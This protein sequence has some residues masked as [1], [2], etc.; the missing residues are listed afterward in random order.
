MDESV[1]VLAIGD[2]HFKKNYIH[3]GKE[4]FSEI[5]KILNNNNYDFVVLLGDI[6]HDHE[7]VDTTTFNLACK[8][9]HKI[10]EY[11]NVFLII[12][13]HDYINN[14]QF[15][16]NNHPFNPLKKWKGVNVIDKPR[17]VQCKDKQFL[18]CPYVYPGRFIEAM[19]TIDDWYLSDCI[20]C[21][22]EFKGCKMGAFI[23]E[24]GDDWDTSYPQVVSGH[25]HDSQTPQDNIF[26]TGS[27]IQHGFNES[28][29]KYIFELLYSNGE[30]KSS[31]I[32]LNVKGKK[33]MNVHVNEIDSF[34]TNILNKY[35]IKMNI[36]GDRS[37]F[38]H[39]RNSSKY[40]QLKDKN[41]KFCYQTIK[42]DD[43]VIIPSTSSFKNFDTILKE[44]LENESSEIKNIYNSIASSKEINSTLSSDN[45]SNDDEESDENIED[46]EQYNDEESEEDN[47]EDEYSEDESE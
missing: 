30:M 33:I 22:Q 25:I 24:K 13:N 1:K 14:T 4:V 16:S 23:S 17:L 15:L 5:L 39:F 27:S 2:L 26:Y 7:V 34:D 20:F 47:E 10:S 19:D 21:H 40:K 46:D 32:K 3:R 18:M 9:I 28:S 43:N 11:T 12:G 35:E 29:S 38:Y 44:V 42:N 36:I 31:K 6:L 37:D 41:V 8:L 45:G